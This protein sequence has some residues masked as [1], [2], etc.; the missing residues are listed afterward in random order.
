MTL[1]TWMSV[2]LPNLMTDLCMKAPRRR[3]VDSVGRCENLVGG[4]LS[5]SCT[6]RGWASDGTML[7]RQ[8]S[9]SE[10]MSWSAIWEVEKAK[11]S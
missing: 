4:E 11:C 9:A 7:D 6:H 3:F 10:A 8:C 1:R 5:V 2:V